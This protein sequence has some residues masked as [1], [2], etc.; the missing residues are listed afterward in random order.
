MILDDALEH[1]NRA[2]CSRNHQEG[3]T[4]SHGITE[5]IEFMTGM[6]E[7]EYDDKFVIAA[8]LMERILRMHPFVDG[9]KRTALLAA[10]IYLRE[11]K[12]YF[13]HRMSN[14]AYVTAFA[15]TEY[16]DDESEAVLIT[17]ITEWLKN[18]CRPFA[19]VR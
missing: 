11:N 5:G 16:E 19:G 9:N 17:M 13:I 4:R 8:R 3:I 10:V 15:A 18:G 14:V 12:H 2:I 7:Q 1:I 6:D